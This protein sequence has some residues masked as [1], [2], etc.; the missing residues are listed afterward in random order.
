MDIVNFITTEEYLKEILEFDPE[1]FFRV[2]SRLFRGRPWQFLSEAQVN[3]QDCSFDPDDILRII[4]TRCNKTKRVKN[5]SSIINSFYIFILH[6]TIAQNEEIKKGATNKPVAFGVRSPKTMH[7]DYGMVYTAIESQLL[8]RP[9]GVS[10]LQNNQIDETLVI[11]ALR[12]KQL[13]KEDIEKLH[14]IIKP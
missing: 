2:I 1:M 9:V 5:D 14:D 3:S 4:E 12:A 6:V 8:P 10:S 11:G 13:K 7:M